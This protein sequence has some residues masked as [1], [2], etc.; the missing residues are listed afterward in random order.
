MTDPRQYGVLICISCHDY[1]RHDVIYGTILFLT[2]PC[3]LFVAYVIELW[4]AD[5]AKAA[6][7]K[8]KRANDSIKNASQSDVQDLRNHWHFVALLHGL[9]ITLNLLVTSLS[10]YYSIH[11][12]GIGTLCELHAIVV[13]LKTSSYAFTNRDLRHAF[14]FRDTTFAVPEIYA[15]CPYPQ[16]IT[17]GNLSYF[18]WAPTLVYQ[19]V[20]PRTE[21]IRWTFVLRCAAEVFAL[22]VAIWIASA[23]YAAPLLQNSLA[24]ISNLDIPSIIERLLKLSSISLFC[25]LCGFFAL[26]QSY[27]NLV[28]EILRFG[29]RA[30][31]HDWWNSA[32]V[33]TY[34]SSW[35]RP[36]Y[37]FMKRHVYLPLVGRGCPPV[38]AQIIVFII[39]GI[40]HEMIV[41]VPTH[42]ILG[43]LDMYANRSP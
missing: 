37:S 30:F 10:V 18:W 19:P 24:T 34:W 25:W 28:A 32:S 20:Y 16:N 15:A 42:N 38:V 1:R 22:S 31:Y 3:H 36:V 8:A 6:V 39:S 27:L 9:N 23:Q 21:R 11:H 41:G 29:D 14:V 13:W 26:F 12:P 43:K 33:R 17:L 35:N 2:V 5:Q 40:L 7:G 4:A